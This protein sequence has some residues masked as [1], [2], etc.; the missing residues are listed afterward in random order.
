MG[1][2]QLGKRVGET[3]SVLFLGSVLF[4]GVAHAGTTSFGHTGNEQS[5]TVPSGV[6]KVDVVVIGGKGGSGASDSGSASVGGFGGRVDVTGLVVTPGQRLFIEVGGNGSSTTSNGGEAGGFNRGGAGGSSG[7]GE[8]NGGGGG[9]GASEIRTISRVDPGTFGSRLVTAGGGGGGGGSV[10]GPTG[11][12]GGT[13]G[14]GLGLS[15]YPGGG[16]AGAGIGGTAGGGALGQG[17][18]GGSSNSGVC[19]GGG[20]GGGGGSEGGRGGANGSGGGAAG[21]GGGGGLSGNSV[22]TFDLIIGSTDNTGV[23]SITF[24]WVDPPAPAQ[25]G[26]TGQRAAALAKCRKN[27]KKNHSKEKLMKCKK[28]AKRLDP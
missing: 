28:K 12:L 25:S 19:G 2:R 6:T 17:G 7:G 3:L 16:D 8:C 14:S 1:A 15:G 5:F 24:T 10:F 27:F 11:A 23:P 20:G 13:G 21:G 26:P 18:A 9:G 22:S 4:S